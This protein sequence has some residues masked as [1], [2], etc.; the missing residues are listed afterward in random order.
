[1][2]KAIT[3]KDEDYEDLKKLN[4]LLA[5]GWTV[6]FISS[7]RSNGRPDYAYRGSQLVIIEKNKFWKK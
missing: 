3:I 7:F 2:E 1:M 5:D 6:K 4:S